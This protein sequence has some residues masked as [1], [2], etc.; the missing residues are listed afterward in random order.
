[1]KQRT[2]AKPVTVV[3]IGLHSGRDVTITF[4][5]SAANKG[6]NFLRTD[7]ENAPLIPADAFLVRDTVMSSNLGIEDVRIGTVEHL[8]SALAGLGIDNLLIKVSDIEV[9]ILDGSSAPYAQL[10]LESG[11]KELDE[12]KRFLKIRKTIRVTEGDKWAELEPFDGFRLEFQIDFDHPAIPRDTQHYSF[13]F[14]TKKYLK[15]VSNA[16]TFGFLQ[17]IELLK[18]SNLALGGSL[19]NAIVIDE[20]GIMN[21]TGLRHKNEFVRHKL[22]DAV[23]D[24]YLAK[25]SL[26]AKFSAY[27]SGHALNNKLIKAVYASNDNF[28]IVTF[29][30]KESSFIN[31]DLPKSSQLC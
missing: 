9:P 14:S 23:G 16:R 4:E 21:K 6:I 10:L 8:L 29:Y 24:L 17:D 12:P 25:Y 1:M 15:S 5:P 30:D 13:D 3:G 18:K 27:K 7:V 11:I 31:Y 19:D 2:L 28:E 20:S 26:L 22:L